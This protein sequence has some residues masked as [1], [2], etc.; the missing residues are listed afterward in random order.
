MCG[1]GACFEEFVE[2]IFKRNSLIG[3]IEVPCGSCYKYMARE[4]NHQK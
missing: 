1:P 4:E 2:E 3:L